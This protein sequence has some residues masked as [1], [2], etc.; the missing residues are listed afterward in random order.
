[1]LVDRGGPLDEQRVWPGH[2]EATDSDLKDP[3]YAAAQQ[4]LQTPVG[5]DAIRMP[6]ARRH[7]TAVEIRAAVSIRTALVAVAIDDTTCKKLGIVNHHSEQETAVVVDITSRNERIE[8]LWDMC[9]AI[10]GEHQPGEEVF[11]GINTKSTQAYE[12]HTVGVVQ[13]GFTCP[14]ARRQQEVEGVA[15]NIDPHDLDEWLMPAKEAKRKFKTDGSTLTADLTAR[16]AH[17]NYCTAKGSE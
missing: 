7:K 9:C 15:E 16:V 13:G 8:E 6:L 5:D 3:D 1:V 12:L 10:S 4:Q 14:N 11:N 2:L 17:I